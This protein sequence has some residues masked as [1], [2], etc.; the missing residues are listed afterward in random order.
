MTE[1]L[2]VEGL[3]AGYGGPPVIEDISL[4]VEP[5]EIAVVLGPNGAGKSTLL[6]AEA[7][8]EEQM[9]RVGAPAL[10][11][12]R[13]DRQRRGSMVQGKKKRARSRR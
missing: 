11:S 3:T 8:R 5:G 6:K 1:Q 9:V 4:S 10:C 12:N 7:S 2:S 13:L